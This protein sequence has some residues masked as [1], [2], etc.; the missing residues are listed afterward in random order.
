[1]IIYVPLQFH[2]NELNMVIYSVGELSQIYYLTS[3]R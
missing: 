3:N 2:V 1:M